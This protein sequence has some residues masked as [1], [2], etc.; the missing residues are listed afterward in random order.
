MLAD[1]MADRGAGGAEQGGR[2]ALLQ[3][4]AL[5]PAIR[6]RPVTPPR[7]H[8]LPATRVPEIRRPHRPV[9]QLVGDSGGFDAVVAAGAAPSASTTGGVTRSWQAR[10][11]VLAAIAAGFALLAFA[12]LA[13]VALGRAAERAE[14]ASATPASTTTTMA[15]VMPA[16]PVRVAAAPVVHAVEIPV[17][18]VKSL[19]TA[20]PVKRARPLR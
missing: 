5:A 18:D 10:L 15:A 8:T 1:R 12:L 7:R 19:P 20:A 3:R 4:R 14:E 11:L 16:A 2:D 17:V 9:L 6:L 13:F